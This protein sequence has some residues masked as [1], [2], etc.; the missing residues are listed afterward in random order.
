MCVDVT[1]IK[2]CTWCEATIIRE[3]Q[4][5]AKW[6]HQ[7]YCSKPCGAKAHRQ[8]YK[9]NNSNDEELEP[10]INWKKRVVVDNG[11][12]DRSEVGTLLT[13]EPI[14]PPKYIEQ[15]IYSRKFMGTLFYK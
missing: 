9:Y 15:M 2:F 13:Y 6:K 10:I 7:L 3:H 11:F 4:T 1:K 8:R 12:V 14:V 5:D